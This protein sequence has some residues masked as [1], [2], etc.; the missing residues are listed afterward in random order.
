MGRLKKFDG[1]AGGIVY[2]DLRPTRPS[3]NVVSEPHSRRPESLDLSVEVIHYQL[4]AI[5]PAGTWLAAIGHRSAGR[6]GLAAEQ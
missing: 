3:H 5:P 1:V 2:Q 6:T 4:D